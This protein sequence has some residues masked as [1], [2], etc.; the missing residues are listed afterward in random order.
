MNRLM[1]TMLGL[2]M[3]AVSCSQ[4]TPG[5]Q[6][7]RYGRKGK[8]DVIVGVAA[9]WTDTSNSL[10]QGAELAADE[11]NSSGGINGRTL[12]LLKG[13]DHG[14]IDGGQLVAHGFG[15]RSDI[16]AVIGHHDTFISLQ[17]AVVY[18]YYE[19]L[20]LCPSADPALTDRG[21]RY[22]FRL[23]P[24][25]RRYAQVLARYAKS[26]G[27]ERVVLLSANGP[28]GKAF[29]NAAQ[30]VFTDAGIQVLDRRTYNPYDGPRRIR[31][32]LQSWK[33]DYQYDAV[34]LAGEGKMAGGAVSLM[35]E[36]G[37]DQPVLT[38]EGMDD[39]AAVEACGDAAAQL[40]VASIFDDGQTSEAVKT[41]VSAFR[42]HYK[43]DPDADAAVAYD[44]VRMLAQTIRSAGSSAP[45]PGPPL[46]SRPSL[47]RDCLHPPRRLPF[48]TSAAAACDSPDPRE[49]SW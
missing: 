48:R 39:A 35:K 7:A 33:N 13:D 14:T 28:Y 44:A 40:R 5:R 23:R 22:V 21:L 1:W 6:R 49:G 12:T 4:S 2:T 27:Y 19:M 47:D 10:W 25:F 34:V 3:L 24:D 26:Q 46:G 31:A 29:G 42:A 18:E 9:N 38:G 20:M 8:G 45:L 11:V 37:L 15:E 16:A 32:H 43:E 17:A 36:M 41:F 30:N